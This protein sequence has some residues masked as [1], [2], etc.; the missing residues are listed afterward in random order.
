MTYKLSATKLVTY[1][2]CPQ[3]YNF[4][5][6]L[7][8][9]SRSAFGSPDLGNALHQALAIAYR[10]WHYNDHKPEWD[11]FE[12][13]WGVSVSKLSEAQIDDGRAILRSYFNDF[14][15]PLNVMQRPLGIESKISAKVQFENIEFALNGRYDR[16]DNTNGSLELIDYK[17]TKNT[18]VP[19]SVDVQLGLYYLA[20]QQVYQQ[21]L[22]RLTL[23]FLRS[24]ESLSFEVTPAHQKQVRSLISDLAVKL[25]TDAEWK[26]KVGGHCDRCTYQK[27]CTAKTC[28]PEPVPKGE[29]RG[30]QLSLSV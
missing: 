28:E 30:V 29:L 5:Y 17:T 18:T 11:W 4:R 27:Y 21:S 20:L 25:R 19:D 13:C 23:I 6:E 3:Q 10:D 16:L 22:K 24:G 7:G 8:I 14:V 12:S 1:K 9:S 2:Q 15:V 26:P